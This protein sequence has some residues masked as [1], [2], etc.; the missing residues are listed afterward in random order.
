MAMDYATFKA[1]VVDTLWKVNDA[2]LAA[3]L[4][5][6]IVQANHD[7]QRT[8][9]VEEK[10]ASVVLP[11]TSSRLPLPSDYYSIRGVAGYNNAYGEFRYISPAQ[12]TALRGMTGS[13]AWEAVY[14]IEHKDLLLCGPV[15][16]DQ[17]STG[18]T[19]PLSPN[20]GTL[21]Y[22]TTVSPGLY[23]WVID[24]DSGQWVQVSSADA[25]EN[26]A[27]LTDTISV[28]VDYTFKIPDFQLTDSSFLTEDYL[29]LYVYTVAKHAAPFLRDDSRLQTWRTLQKEALLEANDDAAFNKQRGVYAS[30]QL[31][32][33]AGIIR[34]K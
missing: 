29:D 9:H 20:E 18:T 27:S 2:K 15:N 1:Y 24:N 13:V 4:D 11:A 21:W 26:I 32:R 8:L 6:I 22:R 19:P 23:V 17:Y 14:S 3:N 5:Y 12:M 31:P 33:Q 10:H 25:S 7:L 28:F 34:R 16:D 30:K